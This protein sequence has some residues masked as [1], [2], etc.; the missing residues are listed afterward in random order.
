MVH[1]E[2]LVIKLT[3]DIILSM[4]KSF[5][6]LCLSFFFILLLIV[7]SF[8]TYRFIHTKRVEKEKKK[9]GRERG[10]D[11]I[12]KNERYTIDCRLIERDRLK[13]PRLLCFNGTINRWESLW[14]L[15]MTFHVYT[16]CSHIVS[17]IVYP[18]TKYSS[19]FT[20]SFLRFYHL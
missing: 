20:F 11:R 19:F 7:H 15:D 12:R 14:F 3:G 4:V 6:N 8:C 9:E 10:R 18:T 13:Y 2:Q 1:G 16:T 5:W 17:T